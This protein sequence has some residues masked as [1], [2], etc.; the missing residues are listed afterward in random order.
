[1]Q[2]S[3]TTKKRLVVFGLLFTFLLVLAAPGTVV[4]ASSH[5]VRVD[6]SSGL[7]AAVTAL[8]AQEE[9]LLAEDIT[10]LSIT[11]SGELT[12]QDGLFLRE[13][14]PSVHTLDLQEFA[15]VAEAQAFRGCT[16]LTTVRLPEHF[17][18]APEMFYGCASLEELVLP[19]HYQIS[20]DSLAYCALD[21]SRGYPSLLN[22]DNV[23]SFAAHQRPKVY[24]TM[25]DGHYGSISAGEVFQ[26]PYHLETLNGSS[27][28]N[29][30]QRAPDWLLTRD[31][32]LQVEAL[33]YFEGEHV[34]EVDTNRE[35]VYTITYTLPYGTN[36]TPSSQ[37][38]RLTVQSSED[39]LP[40]LLEEANDLQGEHY[41]EDSWQLLQD[42]VQEVEDENIRT[43][44]DARRNTLADELSQALAS[45]DIRILGVQD[46]TVASGESFR[47]QPAVAQDDNLENWEY[48]EAVLSANFEEG[49]LVFTANE[50]GVTEV[51]Y[52]APDGKQGRLVL[53]VSQE[54]GVGAFSNRDLLVQVPSWLWPTVIAL[55]LFIVFTL[56]ISWYYHRRAS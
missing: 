35:G 25:P 26:T 9:G 38:Y 2:T 32:D 3:S 7:E 50:E 54:A 18:I 20:K 55:Y 4:V 40:S 52:T 10:R 23:L 15:G 14:L 5:T 47:L 24:F 37:T 33:I 53:Q 21:F 42:T 48:D 11:G 8:L 19:V 27:Y 6:T 28:Q 1:M 41:S 12:P 43:M 39:A 17:V 34:N 29:L 56:L 36:A 51:V 44:S 49:V 22:D 13:N 45:L 16:S 31:E 30:V 46:N